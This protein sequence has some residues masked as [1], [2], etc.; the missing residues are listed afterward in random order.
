M[1]IGK[2][3]CFQARLSGC[4]PY[5]PAVPLKRNVNPGERFLHLLAV[6]RTGL[7]PDRC[8]MN[9][10]CQWKGDI[11]IEDTGNTTRAGEKQHKDKN[12]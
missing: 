9:I 2:I 6:N 8:A 4:V 10:S 7:M 11:F 12:D 3:N 5:G 1:H